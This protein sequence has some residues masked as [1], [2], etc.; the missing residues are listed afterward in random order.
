MDKDSAHDF[1]TLLHAAWTGND[2][3]RLIEFYTVNVYYSDPANPEGLK[4]SDEILPY[5]RRLLARNSDWKWESEEI[6][7]ALNGFVLKWRAVIPSSNGIV[8]EKGLEIVEIRI[9]RIARN[10]VYFDRLPL[11]V[12]HN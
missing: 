8:R 11:R 5:F 6:I 7:P 9:C 12:P 10:K 2:L 3:N 1:C 4:G